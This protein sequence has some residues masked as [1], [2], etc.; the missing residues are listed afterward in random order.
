MTA[1]VLSVRGAFASGQAVRV[2]VRKDAADA[3]S[4]DVGADVR[5]TSTGLP[6]LGQG[7]HL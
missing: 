6:I 4:R 1:G 5:H 7:H 3:D 2:L